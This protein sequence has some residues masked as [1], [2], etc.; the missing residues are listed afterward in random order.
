MHQYVYFVQMW[1]ISYPLM[2]VNIQCITLTNNFTLNSNY[3]HRLY[4]YLN[5][6]IFS[7]FVSF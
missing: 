5:T 1:M 6:N 7:L 3:Q 4:I 2:Q